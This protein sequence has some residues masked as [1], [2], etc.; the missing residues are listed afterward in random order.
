MV[1]STPTFRYSSFP[2][3]QWLGD[4]MKYTDV[5]RLKARL[6]CLIVTLAL[7]YGGAASAQPVRIAGGAAS[8][9]SLPTW[10][11][12]DGGY[13]AREGV[14]AELIYIRGG[15]Q[16]ISALASGEVPF[17]QISDGGARAGA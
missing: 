3:F 11:G 12:H 1:T 2:I 5:T 13:F 17:G 4:I 7:S 15:P 14:P 6:S 8:V 10:V 16:T 9:A